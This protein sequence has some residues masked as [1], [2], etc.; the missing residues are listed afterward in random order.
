M[1]DTADG[2]AA[3]VRPRLT[4]LIA[5]LILGRSSVVTDRS[6]MEGIG[7]GDAGGP[8]RSD[9]CQ[10]LHRQGNQD[11]RKKIPQPPAHRSSPPFV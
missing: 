10:D 11:Y 6:R 2:T 9:R 4:G 7:R 8:A 1:G 3:V 5:G